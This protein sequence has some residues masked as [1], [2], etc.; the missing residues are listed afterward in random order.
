MNHRSILSALALC[1]GLVTSAAQAVTCAPNMTASNPDADYTDHADG[2]VTHVPTG[3]MWKRCAE[4]QSWT[5]STCTGTESYHTWAQ[6]LTQ[7]GAS[8]FAGHGDWRLPNYKEL[9][10]LVEE[11]RNDPAINDTVFPAAQSA[12][13][14]GR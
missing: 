5:G 6:A 12:S 10:S 4:G 11:C 2:T 1:L 3:L 13:H 14:S 7:A 8:S 9:L